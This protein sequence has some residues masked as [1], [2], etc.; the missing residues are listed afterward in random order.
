MR[1]PPPS[2]GCWARPGRDAEAEQYQSQA[3]PGCLPYSQ[4]RGGRQ[5]GVDSLSSFDLFMSVFL[6]ILN[7][8]QIPTWISLGPQYAHQGL[9]TDPGKDPP[10]PTQGRKNKSLPELNELLQRCHS[11]ENGFP[12]WDQHCRRYRSSDL[13][14][15]NGWVMQ[16][17][18]QH[19][20]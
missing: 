1:L 3:V 12:G 16:K 19:K 18:D 8:A 11:M 14:A 6:V 5:L 20:A 7:R 9:A 2:S 10:L 15:G 4:K 13:S 17:S